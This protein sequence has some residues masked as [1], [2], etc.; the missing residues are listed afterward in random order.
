MIIDFHAH[1]G[2]LS[3]YGAPSDAD[4]MLAAMDMAGVD[5]ACV[6]CS[7]RSNAARGNDQNARFVRAHPDRFIG[8]LFVTPH[9]PDEMLV[10]MPRAVDELG[11]K[12]I[13]IYPP[14]FSHDV[15]HPAW[16]PVFAFAHERRLPIISHTD[17]VDPIVNPNRGEPGM[18]VQWARKYPNAS[19]VFAHAGNFSSGRRSCIEAARQC[20]NIF[21]EICSS[22]R[23]FD[24]I[25]ELVAGAGEDRILFGS[26]LPLMDPRV[27][28]GRV[29]T[30]DLSDQAKRKILG[31]NA[32]GLLGLRKK[33]A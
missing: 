20:P 19:I 12:G 22:W 21:I 28:M 10:E 17:G 25:E 7:F 8:F 30:A 13:K 3:H 5:I 27:Q 15:T 33:Q 9:Y 1:V 11:M 6:F 26:D 18:F 29:M 24:S 32:A 4:R 16:E 23:H 14:Y 2:S 31:D